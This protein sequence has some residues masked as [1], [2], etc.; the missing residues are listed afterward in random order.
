MLNWD[1]IFRLVYAR[2]MQEVFWLHR[3]LNACRK[4]VAP[5]RGGLQTIQP[6]RVVPNKRKRWT[7]DR[8]ISTALMGGGD[9][10]ITNAESGS[11]SR[12]YHIIWAPYHILYEWAEEYSF[13]PLTFPIEYEHVWGGRIREN[14][15]IPWTRWRP[16]G[17]DYVNHRVFVRR[18]EA[19]RS[20]TPTLSQT[21]D[22]IFMG[23]RGS[24][25]DS[26]QISY[27]R[28]G[29]RRFIHWPS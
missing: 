16:S 3:E 19:L 6:T 17:D 5:D 1:Q 12:Q 29:W 8:I 22:C 11:P 24:Q 4:Y 20:W 21:K 15:S 23:L 27:R 14:P 9:E 13:L 28:P 26:G 10:W 7:Q 25:S 18:N 2:Y